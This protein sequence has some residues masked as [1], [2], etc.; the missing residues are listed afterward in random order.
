MKEFL[1]KIEKLETKSTVNILLPVVRVEEVIVI[2]IS[3]G[4]ICL[5]IM[6]CLEIHLPL[7]QKL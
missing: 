6:G 7:L 2:G 5:V 4:K 3:L 1:V